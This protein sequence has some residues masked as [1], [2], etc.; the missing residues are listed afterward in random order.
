[1][2]LRKKYKIIYADPP[3]KYDD[4]LNLQNE[5]SAINYKVLDIKDLKELPIYKICDN[6]CILFLWVTMPMLKEGLSLIES[7]GFKYRTCAFCWIKLNP[8]SHTIFKGI[9]RWVMGNAELCLLAIKGKPK[10]IAKNI[11]QVIMSP[12][13]KHSHK[14]IEVR[15]RIV[16]LMGD[17]ARIELFATEKAK[18]WD[19][20][21]LEVDGI[22]IKDFL[23]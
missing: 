16:N 23:K 14:P 11:P 2:A 13:I 5:G 8:K 20:T 12:R 18:N 7:W 3:W 6:D 19:S 21:G 4:R 17:I 9:G 22:D 15:D 1:L 10:R